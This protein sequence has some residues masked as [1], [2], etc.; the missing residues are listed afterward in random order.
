M[1]FCHPRGRPV[2][3]SHLMRCLPWATFGCGGHSGDYPVGRHALSLSL[4]LK[5]KKT[6]NFFFSENFLCFKGRITKRTRHR[7]WLHWFICPHG[8]KNQG[9]EQAE[10][11]AR[12]TI[13]SPMWETE[14]SDCSCHPWPSQEPL[15]E[16]G[17]EAE[18]LNWYLPWNWCLKFQCCEPGIKA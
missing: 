13:A 15:Q 17:S 12:N 11:R 8:L 9:L 5:F 18:Y 4:C 16:A 10:T 2:P 7:P 1:S 6:W 3:R 14:S